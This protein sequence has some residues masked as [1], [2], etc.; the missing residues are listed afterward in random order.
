MKRILVTLVGILLLSLGQAHA[1]IRDIK[2]GKILC[3]GDKVVS[4]SNATG[5]VIGINFYNKRVAVDLDYYSDHNSYDIDE[6]FVGFGCMYGICVGDRVV[7]P[8]PYNDTGTI[9]GINP[10]Y[11]T[12]SVNLDHY[13]NHFSY[14]LDEIF[15][16]FGCVKGVCV[17][18]RVVSPSNIYGSVIGVNPY[19]GSVSVDLDRYSR[20]SSYDVTEIYVTNECLDYSPKQRSRSEW[21]HLIV[22][23]NFNF[24]LEAR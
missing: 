3:P 19:R 13:K 21:P 11:K 15:I 8:N 12:V 6:L 16:G 17:K 23:S 10:Y 1:C 4:P 14:E 18:D 22:D 24:S 7:S 9:I 5:Y 2:G 20:H